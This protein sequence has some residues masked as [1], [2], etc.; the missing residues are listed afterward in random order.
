[1][2]VD[3]L[4]LGPAVG[5]YLYRVGV[6]CD[7]VDLLLVLLVLPLGLLVGRPEVSH[8]SSGLV[9][10]RTLA[11]DLSNDLLKLLLLVGTATF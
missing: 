7:G 8:L 9:V 2:E 6:L 3:I 4:N 1:M 5:L 11:R 10:L